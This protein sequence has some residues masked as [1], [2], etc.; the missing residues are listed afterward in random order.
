MVEKRFCI[1]RRSTFYG[2][3]FWGLTLAEL[4]SLC[5]VHPDLIIRFVHLGLLDPLEERDGV[6]SLF[7]PS[8][9]DRVHKIVRLRRDLGINYVG[10]GVV[11]DLMHRI[12]TL[13]SR[14]RELE[15]AMIG[16]RTERP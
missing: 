11:L 13:E 4:A 9:V 6:P 12:E 15:R 3:H 7:A 10:I 14:L 16:C 2:S 8:S 5:G 1:V